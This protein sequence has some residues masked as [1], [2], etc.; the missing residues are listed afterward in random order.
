LR[1]AGECKEIEVIK[2]RYRP[3]DDR[4][5][6]MILRL[7]G[8]EGKSDSSRVSGDVDLGEP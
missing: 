6:V 5:A 2:G 1:I 8:F 7:R 3:W 4:D